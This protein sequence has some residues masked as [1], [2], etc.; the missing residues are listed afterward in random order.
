MPNSDVAI[1]MVVEIRRLIT[2]ARFEFV[3][4]HIRDV[5]VVWVQLSVTFVVLRVDDKSTT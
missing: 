2:N 1:L 5:E 3:Q 4:M